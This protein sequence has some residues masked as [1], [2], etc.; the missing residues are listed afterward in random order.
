[1]S[2]TKIVALV[3]V[4]L[5]VVAGLVWG[6]RPT[7]TEVETAL[8]DRGPFLD[9]IEE[10]GRTRIRDTYSVAAPIAGYLRRIAVEVGEPV[11]TG[12]LLA[13]VEPPPSPPLD[14]RTH[15]EA[16]A[17]AEA[18]RATL[19][20]SRREVEAAAAQAA[21]A[22][23]ERDRMAPLAADSVISPFEFDRYASAARQ[24]AAAEAAAASAARAAA[25]Q[26]AA[27]NATLSAGGRTPQTAVAVRAPAGGVVLAIHHES[28]GV[29]AAGQPLVEVGDLGDLE[30]VADVLT[31]DAVRI[32]PGTRVLIDGWGGPTVL[33][34]VV[35]RIEPVAF[36]DVT[37]LGVEEQRA[38][39]VV[40]LDPA[41]F[42][43]AAVEFGDGY[44]VTAR[45]VLRESD[46]VIRAPESALVRE[47]DG[48]GAYVVTDDQ[49]RHHAV[50]VG[51]RDGVWAEVL[52][53]LAPGDPVVVHPP[54]DLADGARV[55]VRSRP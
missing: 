21:A 9:T 54:E 2:R 17:R 44:R 8:V 51:Q 50:Q 37:A 40:A 39:V 29:V 47:G 23:R 19:D 41:S 45:F 10:D 11:R 38:R 36:T 18:A 52:G 46:D 15:A 30:V 24:A 5:V 55:A 42:G 20:R 27:A 6:L 31:E 28:E 53:G 34:G 49:A 32:R 16:T 22:R 33:E 3:L 13:V 35:E 48:W 43:E 25:A 26:F 1:M 12:A 14:A 7:P 4:A